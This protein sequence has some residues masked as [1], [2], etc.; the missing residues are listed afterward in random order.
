MSVN[1]VF[2]EVAA[3]ASA[4]FRWQ[5][6]GSSARRPI[7]CKRTDRWRERR[8]RQRWRR[9]RRLG[10]L[11]DMRAQAVRFD[12]EILQGNVTKIEVNRCP[13]K[14]EISD[15][16]IY[17][18]SLIIATGASAGVSSA[19]CSIVAMPPLTRPMRVARPG[20]S[21]SIASRIATSSA[22]ADSYVST[23]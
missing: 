10:R 5:T 9:A 18:E 23:W 19:T 17:C 3:I 20:I 7:A 15:Q 8:A 2:A 11:A 12:T 6:S 16:V 22:R 13:I 21:R 4:S 1:R 14:I